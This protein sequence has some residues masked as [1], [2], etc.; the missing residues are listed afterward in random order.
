M[1]REKEGLEIVTCGLQHLCIWRLNGKN[2]EF[3]SAALTVENQE[4]IVAF[5][6]IVCVKEM[7]VT[8]GDDGKV[9]VWNDHKL[10]KSFP[11]HDKAILCLDVF[12]EQSLLLTGG[13]EGHFIIWKLVMRHTSVGNTLTLDTMRE[14]SIADPSK[15]PAYYWIQS[16]CFSPSQ[17]NGAFRVL[18]GTQTGDIHEL[19][20]EEDPDRDAIHPIMQ[21]CDHLQIVSMGCNAP[22]SHLF[23]LSSSGQVC[24]WDLDKG[25]ELVL[26]EDFEKPAI[27]LLVL[28]TRPDL[29]LAFDKSLVFVR[30][31]REYRDLSSRLDL[32]PSF[33]IQ[34]SE[35]NEIT[36]IAISM[37]E[38][39]L[40]VACTVDRKSH[41]NIYRVDQ[42]KLQ[43]DKN[44]FGFRAPILAL[45]FSTDGFFL[46]CED[47]IGE[48]LLFEIETQNI[49]NMQAVELHIDWN[50]RGLMHDTR[51]KG[52][53]VGYKGG[54]KLLSASKNAS[55]SLVAAGDQ[56]G[57]LRHFH[58]PHQNGPPILV[59]S[60]HAS[61]TSQVIFCKDNSTLISYSES[62][63]SLLKWRLTQ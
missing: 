58:V 45:D 6:A 34:E 19:M 44:L 7:I 39:T 41:V 15:N 52:M 60:P 42:A 11:G 38:L 12:E 18:I 55:P 61:K 9:Y 2:L 43:L 31:P 63:R 21:T 27:K 14:Y 4:L 22:C 25:L 36:D 24:V 54:N 3:T 48:V 33:F 13:I 53:H 32:L 51:L 50:G 1:F 49:A 10:H 20:F 47:S 59:K 56:L 17:A 37:D 30:T 46:L 8:A 62:D 35:I 16:A 29:V 5:L 28:Q 23:T 40:A 57:T 26:K